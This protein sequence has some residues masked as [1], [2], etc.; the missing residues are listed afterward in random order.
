[1]NAII[2]ANAY[3]L[4]ITDKSISWH[5][6]IVDDYIVTE[7]GMVETPKKNIKNELKQAIS[8]QIISDRYAG[9]P[10]DYFIKYRFYTIPIN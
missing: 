3:P 1:M 5:I 9:E 4:I 8:T 7:S 10:V 6:R 2:K